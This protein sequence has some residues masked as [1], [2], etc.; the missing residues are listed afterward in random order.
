MIDTSD[1]EINRDDTKVDNDGDGG[2]FRI[3]VMMCD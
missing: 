2:V 3:L 1:S